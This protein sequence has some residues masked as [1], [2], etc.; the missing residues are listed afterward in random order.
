MTKTK[1]TKAKAA[2]KKGSS[3]A[4]QRTLP[5][6]EKVAGLTPAIPFCEPKGDDN[7]EPDRVSIKLR[8]NDSAADKNSKTNFETKSFDMID[9]FTLKG[10]EVL[11]LRCA[12]NIDIYKPYGLRD[13]KSVDRQLNYF[14]RCLKDR[15]RTVYGKVFAECKDKMLSGYNLEMEASEYSDSEFF[16]FISKD[17]VLTNEDIKGGKSKKDVKLMQANLISGNANCEEFKHMMWFKLGKKM[18][19]KHRNFFY[20]HVEYLKNSIRKLFDMTNLL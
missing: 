20:E 2:R 11:K 4:R 5:K 10:L 3:A 7:V 8:L 16:E 17:E 15:A 9:S 13:P 12:L 14:Q 1:N 19:K 6:G 18:W